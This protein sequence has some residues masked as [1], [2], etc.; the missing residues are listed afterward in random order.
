VGQEEKNPNLLI[1][2]ECLKLFRKNRSPLTYCNNSS[3]NHGSSHPRR[4]K[5]G[6]GLENGPGSASTLPHSSRCPYNKV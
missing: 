6:L 5:D 4:S 1:I 3:S 2:I